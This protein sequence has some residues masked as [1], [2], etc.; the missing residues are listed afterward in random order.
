MTQ[1]IQ[2][3][4]GTC[5]ATLPDASGVIDLT[6]D[7][8]KASGRD[9]LSQSL[10]RRQTTP[11]GSVLTSPND[12]VDLRQLLS[13]GMSQAQLQAT[14]S[15]LRAELLRDQRVNACQVSI[16]VNTATG[17][18][19][20]NEQIQSSLGPFTLVLTLTAGSISAIVAGQ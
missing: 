10:I 14:A 19:T 4:Y 15:A 11:R 16:T 3:P 9:V 17:A 1:P 6:P 8:R 5:L 7:M 2:L 12:C 18:T 20:I 13:A